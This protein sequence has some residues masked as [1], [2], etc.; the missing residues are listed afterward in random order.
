MHRPLWV[1]NVSDDELNELLGYVD[2]IES[3]C[4]VP[5]EKVKHILYTCYYNYEVGLEKM[6]CFSIDVWKEAAY[7][8]QSHYENETFPMC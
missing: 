7:R 6:T 2:E 1:Q 3:S 4:A 5:N 8:W